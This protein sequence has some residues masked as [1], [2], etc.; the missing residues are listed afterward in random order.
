MN[1]TF[2][3]LKA[4]IGSQVIIDELKGGPGF[5]RRLIDMGLLPGTNIE[6]ISGGTNG[7]II[8]A[9]DGIRIG[10][11]ARMAAKIFVRPA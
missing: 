10:I 6:I 3:L 5:Y 2:P 1:N 7:P 4:R 9:K 8:I 11:G